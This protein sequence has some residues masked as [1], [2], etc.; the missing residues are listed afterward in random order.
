MQVS[1]CGGRARLIERGWGWGGKKG[2]DG[3]GRR[4]VNERTLS[5]PRLFTSKYNSTTTTSSTNTSTHPMPRLY[6]YE[7]TH[8]KHFDSW[9]ETEEDG[10]EEFGEGEK[11]GRKGWEE[12]EMQ[13]GRI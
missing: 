7:L 9:N 10:N 11:K 2:W 8:F 13:K 1:A 4:K 6:D 12:R 5:H 3:M